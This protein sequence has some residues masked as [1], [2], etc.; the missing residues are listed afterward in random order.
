MKMWGS[1]VDR[2]LTAPEMGVFGATV[3]AYGLEM[4]GIRVRW[5][6]HRG[7]AVGEGRPQGVGHSRP[8]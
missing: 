7:E 5:V 6:G 4:G 3:G 1:G 8:R 2:G